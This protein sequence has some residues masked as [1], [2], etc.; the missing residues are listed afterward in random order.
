MKK[1]TK[2]LSALLPSLFVTGMAI[3][4]VR[5]LPSMK[6]DP[7]QDTAIYT[8]GDSVVSLDQSVD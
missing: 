3:G 2:V 8:E 7:G 5:N 4:L 1:V 6:E